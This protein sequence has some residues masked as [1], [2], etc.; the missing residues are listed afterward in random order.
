MSSQQVSVTSIG[1]LKHIQELNLA[2]H[3]LA[4]LA[5]RDDSTPQA[6]ATAAT[7][8]ASTAQAEVHHLLALAN[9]RILAMPQ[10]QPQFRAAIRLVDSLALVAGAS[11]SGGI[12]AAIMY[13]FAS[14]QRCPFAPD[15]LSAFIGAGAITGLLRAERF[16]SSAA[17][18]DDYAQFL[19][20]FRPPGT[21]PDLYLNDDTIRAACVSLATAE[22][23]KPLASAV[24]ASARE[25]EGGRKILCDTALW[26]DEASAAQAARALSEG[27]KAVAF[28]EELLAVAQGSRSPMHTGIQQDFERNFCQSLCDSFADYLGC[29]R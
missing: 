19:M 10:C 9:E 1:V 15:L 11:S 13:D 25:N 23:Q 6:I 26:G 4:N 7:A 17:A 5:L 12:S 8:Q 28:A 21:T 3:E 14:Q 27:G 29:R 22:H 16:S 18:A 20:K 24:V 2:A